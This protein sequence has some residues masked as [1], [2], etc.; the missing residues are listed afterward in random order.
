VADGPHDV[1][2]GV[3]E[4][5]DRRA[6]R[7]GARAQNAVAVADP[8]ARE[9]RD[10]AVGCVEAADGHSAAKLDP[11]RR[12]PVAA[13][14]RQRRLVHLAAQELLRERGA[15][16]RRP[17]LVAEQ[18]DLA[19][20]AGLAEGPGDRVAGRAAADDR[21]AIRRGHGRRGPRPG[22]A[23]QASGGRSISGTSRTCG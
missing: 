19:L 14:E 15:A 11:V 12:V 22:P 17:V 7:L 23:G 21:E 4:A 9:R 10:D 1:H 18:H 20:P 16:V 6:R 5:R 13:L 3:G 2:P 8:L